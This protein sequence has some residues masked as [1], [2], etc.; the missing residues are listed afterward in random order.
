[1]F[2]R[3]INITRPHSLRIIDDVPIDWRNSR[4]NCPSILADE[5]WL[6]RS[7]LASRISC[8]CLRI[9]VGCLW[10]AFTGFFFGVNSMM[11][12]AMMSLNRLLI[13]TNANF[14][15]RYGK[16]IAFSLLSL[17]F[18]FALFWS[19]SPMLGWGEYGPEPYKTSC[20]LV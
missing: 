16:F 7:Y 18:L 19:V 9:C 2:L 1:M 15:R 5:I 20:T 10:N 14:A 3:G 6:S 13:I 11:T 12:L 17:S 8:A 4:L